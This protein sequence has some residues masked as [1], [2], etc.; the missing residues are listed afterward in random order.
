MAKVYLMCGKICSGKSTH[1]EALRRR[2]GAVVLSVDEI[3]LALF[4]QDAGAMHDTYVARMKAYLY[5][6]SVQIA[7]SGVDVILDWGFW[8]R[9]ERDA[10]RA[11]YS[12]R[13]IPCELHYISVSDGEWRRRLQQ[14]NEDILA[15]RSDA[16]YVD[17]GLRAKF[18]AIFEPPAPE[19]VAV[20]VGEGA[21]APR[22]P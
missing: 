7:G 20:W 5:G 17:D 11:M 18:A 6:K 9:E 12:R 3:M 1:A 16:Y 21:E 4:G 8:T 14:R 10:A 19:E 13:H 2:L 15:G 22:E